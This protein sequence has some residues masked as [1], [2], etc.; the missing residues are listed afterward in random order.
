MAKTATK[1]AGNVFYQARMEA[2]SFN[3]RLKSREGASEETGIDR[4][5][6]AYIELDTITPYPEEVLILSEEY[7]APELCNHY[8]SKMCAL[9][10]RTVHP[11]EVSELERVVLQ[12]LSVFQSLPTVKEELI[13]IAADGVIDNNEMPIMEQVIA[14]LDETANKIEALKIYFKKHYCGSDRTNL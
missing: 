14:K 6:I 8:C 10:K 3:D 9:G 5:R 4:T 12:L 1:A 7:N 13:T 11:V 2:S